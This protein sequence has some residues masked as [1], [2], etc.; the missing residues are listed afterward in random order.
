VAPKS[1]FRLSRYKL[2]DLRQDT[3]EP[4]DSFLKYVRLL[5]SE[6]KCA[7]CNEQIIDAIIFGVN[8]DSVKTKLMKTR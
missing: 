6:C 4:I 5:G 2:R 3:G 7:D 8:N 1:N